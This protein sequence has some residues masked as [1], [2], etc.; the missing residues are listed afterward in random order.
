MKVV[1]GVSGSIAA[2]K[3]VEVMREIQ[4]A[5]GE[6]RVVM[7]ESAKKFVSPLTFKV[8]SNYDVFV[9]MFDFN[10]PLAHINFAKWADVFL[11]APATANT[12]AK[13]ALG[14]ADNSLTAVALALPPDRK[15]IIVPAMNTFMYL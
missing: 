7:S 1:L 12:I 4:R 5:G 10:D 14:L 15:K 13:I 9:D 6:V 8:L 3:S 2:F 11:L